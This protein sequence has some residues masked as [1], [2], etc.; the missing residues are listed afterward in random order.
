MTQMP[1]GI[2]HLE[3]DGTYWKCEKNIWWHWNK[4][5]KRW[6]QYVGLVNQNFLDVR[7]PIVVEV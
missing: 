4:S 5:F 2:T 7:M 3:N 6:C 1:V